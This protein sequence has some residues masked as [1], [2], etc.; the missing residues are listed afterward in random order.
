MNCPNCGAA[1]KLLPNRKH[2]QCGHCSSL[3]FPEPIGEGVVLLDREHPHNCPC[4]N[5][6][7]AAAALDGGNV[8]YCGECHG[9]LLESD[10]FASVIASR[11]ETQGLRHQIVEPIDPTEFRRSTRCPKC[12]KRNDTHTYG[13]GGNAV[14]DSCH[15]CRLVWLD[16]G[17][18]TVLERFSPAARVQL[19]I[20]VP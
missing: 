20:E 16:A 14:I 11:R 18:L 6:P 12:G 10:H 8:G 4:C 19:N 3:H 15:R 1:L 17:E 7:L 2:F 9:L 5:R 13:G